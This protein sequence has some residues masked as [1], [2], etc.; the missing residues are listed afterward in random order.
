MTGPSNPFEGLNV[1]DYYQTSAQDVYGTPAEFNAKKSNPLPLDQLQK[2]LEM[3]WQYYQ[4][5]EGSE[6]IDWRNYALA[7]D[8]EI[9]ARGGTPTVKAPEESKNEPEESEEVDEGEAEYT[10]PYQPTLAELQAY[11]AQHPIIFAGKRVDASEFT[12]EQYQAIYE[13]LDAVDQTI[14]QDDP[15]GI[16]N[17]FSAGTYGPTEEEIAAIR[18]A[19]EQSRK[20]AREEDAFR[21]EQER[22]K[23]RT[24]RDEE[25]RQQKAEAEA[26]R[27][28]RKQEEQRLRIERERQQQQQRR[29]TLFRQTALRAAQ[30][31]GRANVRLGSLPTPGGIPLLLFT[32][33]FI[34]FALVP[35]NKSGATRLQ[36]LWLALVGKVTLPVDT[37]SDNGEKSGSG[38]SGS[39]GSGSGTGGKPAGPH[40]IFNPGGLPTFQAE[41]A[42]TSQTTAPGSSTLSELAFSVPYASS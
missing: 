26:E 37:E 23:R 41:S 1:G 20:E 3:A 14:G 18:A 38:G 19:K 34:I 16:L 30:V 2:Q 39:G 27:Q 4:R 8:R 13:T 35:Q 24:E 15:D 32:I 5:A 29:T 11:F 25:R 7:L 40:N 10:P 28:Q 6:R 31:T 36:L 22:V 17:G 21:Q 42:V 33:L 9:T 12:R